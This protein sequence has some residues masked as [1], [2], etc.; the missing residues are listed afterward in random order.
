MFDALQENLSGAFR[1]LRGRGKLSEANRILQ[2]A[3]ADYA[4]HP[5]IIALQTSLEIKIKQANTTYDAYLKAKQ[6]AGD[7]YAGLR[8]SR[9]LLSRTQSIWIDNPDYDKAE[10][11]LDQLIAN[12]PDNPT[13]KVIR[14]ER[15]DL[16]AV[17]KADLTRAKET[18]KPI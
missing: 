1:S 4:G 5:D 18:W 6:A 10:T 15:I 9:K 14:R 3:I 13:K 2:A 11:K 17:S 12:A 16:A 7:A 8:Q